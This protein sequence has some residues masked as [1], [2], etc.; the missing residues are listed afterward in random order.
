[1]VWDKVMTPEY[2]Q[3][4]LWGRNPWLPDYKQ[5]KGKSVLPAMSGSA[6]SFELPGLREEALAQ[7]ALRR[8]F[9]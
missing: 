9:L 6:T 8:R 7:N 3:V 5:I 2:R 1:M 4:G